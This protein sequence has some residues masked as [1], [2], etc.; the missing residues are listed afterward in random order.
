M[1]YSLN[2]CNILI[3]VK[4]CILHFVLCTSYFVLF[5]DSLSI[6]DY[7]ALLND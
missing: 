6:L 5:N 3:L 4:F 7:I 2:T 1:K